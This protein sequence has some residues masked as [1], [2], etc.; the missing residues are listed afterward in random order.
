[1][2]RSAALNPSRTC[3][4]ASLPICRMRRCRARPLPSASP[5]GLRC[6]VMRKLRPARMR[7]ATSRAAASGF[8]V[9]VGV[10]VGVLVIVRFEIV[11][12]RFDAARPRRRVVVAEV[13]LR[14]VAE[15]DALAEERA[16][17]RSALL[18]RADHLLRL[19]FLE[20]AHEDAREVEVGA[21]LDLVDRGQAEVDG[22]H[23]V[24]EDLDE[25]LAQHLADSRCAT[26]LSHP[27]ASISQ[28]LCRRFA[29]SLS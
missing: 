26:G 21:D 18:Q 3:T 23:V 29:Y 5:S 11:E 12:Q 8:V 14:R 17:P 15:M 1:M 16:D 6:E 10:V 19:L 25:R 22:L 24:A 20:A 4:R 27:G 28:T 13:E 9:V 7:S 2:W